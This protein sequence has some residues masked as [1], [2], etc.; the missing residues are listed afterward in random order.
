VWHNWI[1][2]LLSCIVASAVVM[3][4]GCRPLDP[5]ATDVP[6]RTVAFD[7]VYGGP[8]RLA[9]HVTIDGGP[10]QSLTAT[11]DPKTCTFK[12]PLTNARH[13]LAISVEQGGRRSAP[14]RVTVDTST[15]R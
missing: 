1:M 8:N 3:L 13:E 14:S 4:G 7:N 15:L 11:C 2:K 12:L 9:I 5:P 6:T 10:E